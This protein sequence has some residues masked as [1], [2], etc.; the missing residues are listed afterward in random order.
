[1]ASN[2]MLR[3]TKEKLERR[4]VTL[5]LHHIDTSVVIEP[6]NTPDGRFCRR[7]LQKVSY[8]YRGVFSAPVL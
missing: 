6:E 5:P 2:N 7:Y 4:L 8:N 1:M 3:K